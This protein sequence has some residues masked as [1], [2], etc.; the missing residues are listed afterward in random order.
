VASFT[1]RTNHHRGNSPW[2]PPDRK[3]SGSQNQIGLRGQKEILFLSREWSPDYPVFQALVIILTEVIINSAVYS[4]IWKI[5]NYSTDMEMS[6]FKGSEGAGA[7]CVHI[8]SPLTSIQTL[9][10]FTSPGSKS[11]YNSHLCNPRYPK[12]FVSVRSSEETFV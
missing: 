1:P 11:R 7:L 8:I 4:L 12:W 2:Y 5:Y 9:H 10:T 6:C 3:L